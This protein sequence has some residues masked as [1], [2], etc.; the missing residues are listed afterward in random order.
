MLIFISKNWWV[1][2]L[3]G[4]LAIAF[5]LIALFW[6][7]VT[8]RVLILLFGVYVFLEGILTT[9]SAVKHHKENYWW[10]LLLEGLTGTV[11]GV[12]AFIWPGLTAV[13]ILILIA[14]WAILTGVVEIALAIQLRKEITGEWIL[15]L[16]GVF[17]IL[18]GV[19]VIS[20][21]GAGALAVVWLIGV[22]AVIFGILMAYLGFKV[23]N[24]NWEFEIRG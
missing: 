16:A 2:V 4:I 3:R 20:R 15:G 9:A 13:V 23:R 17:S 6:P 22:Y 21:P 5:G 24:H 1:Y 18:V 11:I 8:L 14:I 19:L 12:F 10:L 7:G